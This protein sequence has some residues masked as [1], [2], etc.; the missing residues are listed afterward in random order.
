MWKIFLNNS[1]YVYFLFLL[2]VQMGASISDMFH[3]VGKYTAWLSPAFC[4]GCQNFYMA[5]KI[6]LWLF[7]FVIAVSE[8]RLK[9]V[10][11]GY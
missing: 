2:S 5:F 3:R 8:W 4:I 10:N 6:C 11:L 9:N 1:K 7:Y